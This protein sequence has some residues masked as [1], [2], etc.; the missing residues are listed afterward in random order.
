MS[1]VEWIAVV[2]CAVSFVGIVALVL[3]MGIEKS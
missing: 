3:L 2:I 1:V